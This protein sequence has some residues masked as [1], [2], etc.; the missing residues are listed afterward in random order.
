ME[1]AVS[2]IIYRLYILAFKILVGLI[3]VIALCVSA[4]GLHSACVFV[5]ASDM[6]ALLMSA[7]LVGL[8]LV[9]VAVLVF[10]LGTVACVVFDIF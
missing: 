4:V 6:P 3:A 10:V 2:D 1:R 5:L 9:A 7:S 8:G